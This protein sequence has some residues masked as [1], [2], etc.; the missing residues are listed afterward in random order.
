[1]P[2][3]GPGAITALAVLLSLL[4]RLGPE[5]RDTLIPLASRT[6]LRGGALPFRAGVELGEQLRL[7]E[8]KSDVLQLT[9]T[10]KELLSGVG[11]EPEPSDRFREMVACLALTNA[12]V[13]ALGPTVDV[14]PSAVDVRRADGDVLLEWLED[15]GLVKREADA[16][17]LVG[18]GRILAVGPLAAPEDP[19]D[20]RTDVGIIGEE[21]SLRYEAE[22]LGLRERP[23][24][25][26]RISSAFGFDILSRSGGSESDDM[27]AVEV[28]AS[29]SIT[30][31]DVFMTAHEITVAHC[32]GGPYWLHAWGEIVVDE[33]KEEQYIRL[34][35]SGYPVVIRH[36]ADALGKQGVDLLTP[37]E[38][39]DGWTVKVSEL[40]WALPSP[41]VRRQTA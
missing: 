25:V 31:V 17:T 37:R 6:S 3:V 41:S 7:I 30:Q 24:Q 20:L 11:D 22:R 18:L 21:L 29:C 1:M 15:V 40:K 14:R 39:R 27:I 9:S 10:G 4:G 28:K 35:R 23:I 34:R 19:V 36:V 2:S 32:L 16:W 13:R 12:P 5:R 38:S 26:S 8:Q 33:P